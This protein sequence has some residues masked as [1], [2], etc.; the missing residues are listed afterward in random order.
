MIEL[1]SI[2]VIINDDFFICEER[3]MMYGNLWLK[4]ESYKR[5]FFE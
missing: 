1:F 4:S 2:V 5:M 3:F